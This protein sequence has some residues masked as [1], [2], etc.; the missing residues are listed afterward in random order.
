MKQPLIAIDQLANT[1]VWAKFDCDASLSGWRWLLSGFGHADETLSARAWRLR[2]QSSAWSI[3]R[4]EL[5]R[6]AGW[7]GDEDHCLQSWLSEFHRRQL[8]S[9][10]RDG[11][12]VMRSSGHELPPSNS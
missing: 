9:V 8:P 12:V 6:V 4:R 2:H 11:T 10:Y 5:D 1:L 3:F 7:L